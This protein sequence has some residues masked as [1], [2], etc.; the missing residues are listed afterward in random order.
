[1]KEIIRIG[2]EFDKEEFRITLEDLNKK[3]DQLIEVSNRVDDIWIKLRGMNLSKDA[4][5][6]FVDAGKKMSEAV[7]HLD[8]GYQE[9][10]KDLKDETN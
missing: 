4:I 9:A 6:H 10:A 1:M 5:Q 7:E 8:E 2:K 3:I